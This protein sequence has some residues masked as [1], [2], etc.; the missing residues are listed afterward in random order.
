MG[1]RQRRF[2]HLGERKAE[3]F[4]YSILLYSFLHIMLKKWG[5]ANIQVFSFKLR[6]CVTKGL[7]MLFFL[8]FYSFLFLCVFE[9]EVHRL[10][11]L[12]HIHHTLCERPRCRS[13][14]RP[15]A[16]THTSQLSGR[17]PPDV[18]PRSPRSLQL[19]SAAP[20]QQLSRRVSPVR[21]RRLQGISKARRQISDWS[22]ESKT[23][24]PRP[25]LSRPPPTGC[26]P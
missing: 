22:G 2:Y 16:H 21:R 14:C 6:C 1:I 24:S 7:P 20:S 15:R 13:R 12:L 5:P 26:L 3:P 8:K 11:P 17:G 23:M 10:L 9:T 18:T 4:F 19:T 25:R